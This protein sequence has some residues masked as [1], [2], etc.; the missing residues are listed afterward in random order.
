MNR[1]EAMSDNIQK[2]IG[3]NLTK[4]SRD[5]RLP[6]SVSTPSV[7]TPS[8]STPYNVSTPS[9]S[10]VPSK[11]S[12]Q[13][14]LKPPTTIETENKS[15]NTFV[16]MIMSIVIIIIIIFVAWHYIVKYFPELKEKIHKFFKIN[17][18]ES[19]DE[20]QDQNS[21]QNSDSN[22]APDPADES[23]QSKSKP[24]DSS[25]FSTSNNLNSNDILDYLLSKDKE[26]EESEKG[27]W[28]FIGSSNNTRHC[29]IMEG[30]KCMSGNVFPT[31]DLCVNPKLKNT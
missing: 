21:D 22:I 26:N 17:S 14:L 5:S 30:N 28:C 4:V 19:S 13:P 27:E 15:T 6:K 23:K 2:F 9:T 10:S 20:K 11:T 18:K 7:S 29:S 16:L 3:S 8:V 24:P 1:F 31:R 25:M 12:A